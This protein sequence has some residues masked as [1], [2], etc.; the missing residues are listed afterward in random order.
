[1]PTLPADFADL[2]RFVHVFLYD[3]GRERVLRQKIFGLRD[4]VGDGIIRDIAI[5]AV[6]RQGFADR[7]VARFES[8]H[9]E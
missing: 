6:R 9:S 4:R 8:G 2:E 1:M 5:G 3:Y 7:V